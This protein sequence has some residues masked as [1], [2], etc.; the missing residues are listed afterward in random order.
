MAITILFPSVVYRAQ[1][2]KR[3]A[4]PLNEELLTA[5]QV[6][7]QDDEAGLAWCEKHG[8]LGYTSYG[9]LND[10][11][12]RFPGFALLAKKL[13]PHAQ[14]FADAAAFDLGKGTLEL[15]SLWVNVLPPGAGHSGHIHPLSV[16]SGTYYVAMPP[17]ASALRFEDPRLGLMMAAP[18]RRSRGEQQSFVSLPAKAGTVL[19]WESWQRHEVPP[20]QGEG[21][22]VS[23]SFN[24][25]WA[26]G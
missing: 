9:S 24:Y 4:D 22:R 5:A 12:W 16:I 25:R 13:A 23:V 6:L 3:V 26:R 19:M 20:N 18:P 10:L 14:T 17:G 15:D 21:D 2:A 7:A 8:Y 1:L 11:T